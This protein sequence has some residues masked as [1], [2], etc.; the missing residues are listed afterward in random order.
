LLDELWN[1]QDDKHRNAFP[2]SECYEQISDFTE[3]GGYWDEILDATVGASP[4]TERNTRF[5]SA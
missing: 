3:K 5:R 2:R 4:T 1:A